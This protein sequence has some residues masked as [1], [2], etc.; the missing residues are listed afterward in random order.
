MISRLLF[1]LLF[2]VAGIMH[3]LIP[4]TYLKIMPPILPHPLLL[5]YLSGAAEF[6]GGIGILILPHPRPGRLGSHRPSDR[7]LARQYLHGH[8]SSS[9]PHRPALGPLHP[10]PPATPPHR[11]GLALHP[12]PH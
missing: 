8:G 12:T 10:H 1:A 7:R 11:L 2:I 9:L 4:G 6:L 3:F 5:V